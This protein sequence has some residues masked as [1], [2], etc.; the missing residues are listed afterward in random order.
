MAYNDTRR[1]YGELGFFKTIETEPGL[2]SEELH[3]ACYYGN[4]EKDFSKTGSTDKINSDIGISMQISIMADAYAIENFRYL[5]YAEY[6]GIKWRV[7]SVEPMHPRLILTLG[8][9]YNE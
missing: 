6:M 7:V 1:Y 2:Y 9:E 3:K 4:V 8:G 5:R